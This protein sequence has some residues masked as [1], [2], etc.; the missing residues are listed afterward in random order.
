MRAFNNLRRAAKVADSGRTA[1][2]AYA[3]HATALFEMAET[4][5]AAGWGK[6]CL[7][8]NW[9]DAGSLEHA[10]E[11]MVEVLFALGAITEDEAREQHGV[12]L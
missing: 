5:T 4:I 12:I 8:A 3:E 9:A 6:D 10:R 7:Q 2:R 11:K 1:S